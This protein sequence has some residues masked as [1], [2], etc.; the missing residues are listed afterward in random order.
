MVRMLASGGGII[1][2]H[3]NMQRILLDAHKVFM[4]VLEVHT[5]FLVFVVGG[6][7]LWV[8]QRYMP[9]ASWVKAFPK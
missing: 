4:I 1:Q 8:C 6:G 2:L 7:T 3:L 9:Q 5:M